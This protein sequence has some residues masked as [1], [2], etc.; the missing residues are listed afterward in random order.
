MEEWRP[1]AITYLLKR[2][3]NGWKEFLLINNDDKMNPSKAS[4]H[5]LHIFEN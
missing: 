5:F 3:V 4:L 2:T 1:I